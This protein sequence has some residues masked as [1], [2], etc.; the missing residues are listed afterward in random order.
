[1][2]TDVVEI[3]SSSMGKESAVKVAAN[4]ISAPG[5]VGVT[6]RRCAGAIEG[7]QAETIARRGS[8]AGTP[9]D[10]AGP[11]PSSQ[12]TQHN[13]PGERTE[14]R[15]CPNWGRA[16]ERN[17]VCQGLRRARKATGSGHTAAGCSILRRN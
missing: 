7:W 15:L 3:G 5:R 17:R 13:G 16:E 8:P 4:D 2:F 10:D 12:G 1:M 14:M 11:A 6:R 9:C